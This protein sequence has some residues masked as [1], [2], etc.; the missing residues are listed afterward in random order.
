M[1]LYPCPCCQNMTLSE[2]GGYEICP[3]CDWEDD[4]IQRSDQEY[5]GGANV[6]SLREARVN[7]KLYG[8]SE[9]R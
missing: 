5:A 3:V 8:T 7:F 2:V 4:P 6:P 9:P 1:D